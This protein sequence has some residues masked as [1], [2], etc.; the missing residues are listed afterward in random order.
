LIAEPRPP[1]ETLFR[2]II[3][4]TWLAGFVKVPFGGKV[5]SVLT[6]LD[7][8]RL[9]LVERLFSVFLLFPISL[10]AAFRQIRF[11]QIQVGETMQYS[12][13]SGKHP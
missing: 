1:G 8:F 2:A 9:G 3:F 4:A 7:H 6:F 10:L 5:D 11:A 12:N 13:L